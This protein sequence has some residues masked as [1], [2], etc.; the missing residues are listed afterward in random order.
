[1]DPVKEVVSVS[2]GS[3]ARDHTVEI[4]LLGERF[5]ISRQGTD[6][7]FA[8]ACRRFEELDGRVDAFGM[9]GIDLF[10]RAAGH[11]YYFR[12]ARK[13]IRNV[14]QTPVVCG[15][16]LKGAV[17]ASTVRYMRDRLGLEFE[18]KRCLAPSAVD[19]Y[20]LV[21]ALYGAGCSMTY[22]DLLYSLG[23]P[24][25]IHRWSTLNMTVKALAPI[26]V[27]LPFKWLYPTG[28]TQDSQP[29]DAGRYAHLYRDNDIVAGDFHYVAKYMPP[30]MS[31]KWIITNTTTAADVEDLRCRGVELLVTSTP[32]IEG[33][34]F[35]TNVIEATL[36][37][38]KGAKGPLPES[39]YIELLDAVGFEPDVQW[40]QRDVRTAGA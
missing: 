23:I 34:S 27:K 37:A 18:G 2:I 13:L 6:G 3:S 31:G 19:R 1:M 29:D 38:L 36:V 30:D 4:D 26:A 9:G 24:V 15:S 28:D 12:D 35:G 10:L 14:S 7:D 17:E 32:R 11:D 20:G 25:M 16:G 21:E 22:G 39:E 33:R 40:L 5:R 8:A